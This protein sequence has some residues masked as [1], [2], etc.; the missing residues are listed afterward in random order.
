MT[1]IICAI[2]D[3][4]LAA[5]GPP[6]VQLTL[7]QAQRGFADET[8]KPGTEVHTHPEDYELWQIGTYDANTG[9][10]TPLEHKLIAQAANL[11]G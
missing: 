3:I 6:F 1:H 5:F 4:K 10:V 7:G 8:N 11:K 9:T 2:R